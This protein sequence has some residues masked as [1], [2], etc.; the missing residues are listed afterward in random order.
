MRKIV[1]LLEELAAAKNLETAAN[2]VEARDHYI[3]ELRAGNMPNKKIRQ[4]VNSHPIW[5]QELKLESDQAV[6]KIDERYCLRHGIKQ[7]KRKNPKH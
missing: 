7:E 3:H 4:L 6:S 2:P 1:S 5:G